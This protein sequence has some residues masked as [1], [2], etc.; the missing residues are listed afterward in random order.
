VQDVGG[1][2]VSDVRAVVRLNTGSGVVLRAFGPSCPPRCTPEQFGAWHPLNAGEALYACIP[3]VDGLEAVT[4]E[5]GDVVAIAGTVLSSEAHAV[6]TGAVDPTRRSQGI[7]AALLSALL[8][9]H[10]GREVAVWC[11]DPETAAPRL[12][13]KNGFVNVDDGVTRFVFDLDDDTA[14]A[15]VPPGCSFTV[16]PGVPDQD[17]PAVRAMEAEWCRARSQPIGPELID[18]YER[19][20]DGFVVLARREDEVIGLANAC[21]TLAPGQGETGLFVVQPTAR[22]AGVGRALKATQLRVAREAGWSRLVV[23]APADAIA[24]V[25]VND[26]LGARRLPPLTWRRPADV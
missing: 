13:G 7:G 20:S 24:A 17:R 3:L 15:R 2:I 16:H 18:D 4:V 10:Q 8:T 19:V 25:K 1:K 6:V 22:C 23:H 9:Q 14:S 26:L 21:R 11:A 5:T 12:L